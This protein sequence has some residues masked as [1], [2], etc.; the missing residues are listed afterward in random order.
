MNLSPL[1][2][3][4]CRA[5]SD[6][7]AGRSRVSADV[8]KIHGMSSPKVRHLVNNLCAFDGC[9]YLEVGSWKGST[10][11]SALSG[12]TLSRAVAFENFA[13]FTDPE[14][15]EGSTSIRDQL[16]E[17]VKKYK[18]INSVDVVEADFFTHTHTHTHA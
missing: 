15:C 16:L 12:N 13:E 8:L 9:S 18:G 10:L 5:V 11:C 17:N 3:Q 1:I 14:H 6:A 7:E 4:A 2:T